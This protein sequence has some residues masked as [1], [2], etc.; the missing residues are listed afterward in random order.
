M[1]TIAA[2]LRIGA[3]HELE[4]TTSKRRAKKIAQDHLREDPKYYTHLLRMEKKVKSGE[5]NP[6]VSLRQQ[7]FM[8]AEYGRKKAGKKTR[9]SMNKQQLREFCTKRVVRKK[10]PHLSGSL[11]FIGVYNKTTAQKAKRLLR[12]SGIAGVKLTSFKDGGKSYYEIY[13]AKKRYDINAIRRFIKIMQ[14]KR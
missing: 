3:R 8:C 6:S 2:Q 9:T 1:S 13:V 10:N 12:I 4:H 7:R 14:E 11:D 5:W